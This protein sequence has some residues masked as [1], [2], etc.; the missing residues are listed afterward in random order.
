LTYII[1]Q[2]GKQAEEVSVVSFTYNARVSSRPLVS[3]FISDTCTTP[4]AFKER[5]SFFVK[6]KYKLNITIDFL[7]SLKLLEKFRNSD[8]IQ[9]KKPF[10]WASC[11]YKAE[12]LLSIIAYT[13]GEDLGVYLAFFTGSLSGR[14]NGLDFL[15]RSCSIYISAS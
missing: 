5:I 7:H 9:K 13:V 12:S 8:Q 1:L 3:K 11:G 14:R 4:N 15:W 6:I 2:R 10:P